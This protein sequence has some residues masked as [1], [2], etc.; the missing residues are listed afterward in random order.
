MKETAKNLE[1]MSQFGIH[2][3]ISEII[4]ATRNVSEKKED[5]CLFN[6][7]PIGIIWKNDKMFLRLFP[8]TQTYENLMREEYFTANVT[9]DSVLY[10]NSTFYDLDDSEFSTLD[11][12]GT[13]VP[14]LK[15]TDRYVVFRCVNRLL[16]QGSMIIDIEP[17]GFKIQTENVG[18][19]PNRGFYSVIEIC[20][21]LTRYEKTKDPAYIE[22]IKHHW[23]LVQ[24]CGR[25]RDKEALSILKRRLSG[26]DTDC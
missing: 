8:G 10:V 1:L 25:K 13:I 12:S 23:S 22:L 9:T 21:H 24:R 14:A 4:A 7:A 15:G 20:V 19:L 17:V 2:E 3:G 26:F 16:A 6:A 11:F 5:T 18:F